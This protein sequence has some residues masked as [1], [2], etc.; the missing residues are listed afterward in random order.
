MTFRNAAESSN[1]FLLPTM[2][3]EIMNR[4]FAG[5]IIVIVFAA[6]ALLGWLA[7]PGSAAT[8]RYYSATIGPSTTSAGST[9][10]AYSITITNCSD[11][12]CPG[13]ATTSTQQI[14]SA[15][16]SVP[17]SFS[18]V[19]S[20]STSATGGKTWTPSLVSGII[21]LV[22]VAGTQKLNQGESVTVSFYANAPCDAMSDEWSTNAYNGTDFATPY[23]LVG[24]QPLVAVTGSCAAFSGWLDHD[25]CTYTQGGWGTAANGNNPGSIRSAYFNSVYPSGVEVG[26]PGSGV[27]SMIFT[28]SAAVEAY[29]PAGG[30]AGALTGDLTDPT[31]SSSGVFGGQVLALRI[32]LDFNSAGLLDDVHDDFGSL[33]LSN[34]S[35]PFDGKT[36]LEVLQYA[37]VALGG[38]GSDISILN[39]IVTSLNEAFDNCEPTQWARDHLRPGI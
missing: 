16:I 38:T 29:L 35:T 32:N 37:D 5:R 12:T 26:V 14:G 2:G 1:Y 7:A 13:Y 9:A 28:S 18:S 10:V 21:R 6:M 11:A 4:K 25:Y 34:T 31:S 24:N 15:T 30:K 33:V 8:V 22:A 20:L 23:T 39:S 27:Y 17:S 3:G 36:V 19:N